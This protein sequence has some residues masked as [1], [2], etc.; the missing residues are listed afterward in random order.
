MTAGEPEG[1]GGTLMASPWDTQESGAGGLQ[2][3]AQV[4]GSNTRKALSQPPTRQERGAAMGQGQGK[5]K[6]RRPAGK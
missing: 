3:G 5:E 4:G 2:V 6:K 1:G